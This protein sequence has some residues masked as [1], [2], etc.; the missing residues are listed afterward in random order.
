MLSFWKKGFCSFL[1]NLMEISAMNNLWSEK[2]L[3]STPRLHC[4]RLLHKKMSG[5][6]LELRIEQRFRASIS[7]M[8]AFSYSLLLESL[9]ESACEKF[10]SPFIIINFFWVLE[11]KSDSNLN[12][13]ILIELRKSVSEIRYLLFCGGLYKVINIQCRS[14]NKQNMTKNQSLFHFLLLD[15]NKNLFCEQ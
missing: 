10:T 15:W 5:K 4:Y 2:E 7:F 12:N 14:G 6:Q 13:T 3:D 9:F 1:V 8:K 11:S